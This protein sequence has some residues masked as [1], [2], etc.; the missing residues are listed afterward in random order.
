MIRILL[1][2]IKLIYK[3]RQEMDLWNLASICFHVEIESALTAYRI[4]HGDRDDD[5][6]IVSPATDVS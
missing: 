4:Q 5:V 6:I 2:I 3:T 1:V